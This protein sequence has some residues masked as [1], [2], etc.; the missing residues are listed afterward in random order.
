MKFENKIVLIHFLGSEKT[1]FTD[2][3][4]TDASVL[5]IA[6]LCISSKSLKRF[7]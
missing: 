2:G 3:W 1:H 7:F 5:T 4:T 6:L